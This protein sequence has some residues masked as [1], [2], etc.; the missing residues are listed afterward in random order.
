VITSID[1]AISLGYNPLKINCVVMRGLNEDEITDFVRWTKDRAVD[2]RFIEYMPFDG[3]KWDSKKMIPYTEIIQI[4]Q[5]EFP[6][7][8]RIEEA[9]TP[10]DTSKA[11][12]VP[13]YKGKRSFRVT[14]HF[15][16]NHATFLCG[17]L[18]I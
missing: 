6:D 11:W 9:D 7:F 3:N 17:Y 2:V 16:W 5:N 10:N 1:K 15:A 18:R 4:I 8:H 13:G 12:K 14:E